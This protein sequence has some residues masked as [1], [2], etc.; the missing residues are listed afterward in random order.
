MKNILISVSIALLLMV[1]AQQQVSNTLPFIA[2]SPP[3]PPVLISI[4]V[5]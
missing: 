1:P 3:A 5:Q 2:V 4:V